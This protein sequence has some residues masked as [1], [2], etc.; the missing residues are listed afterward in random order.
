[1]P[2][3]NNDM[4]V[5][6]GVC[7][8]ECPVNAIT[9]QDDGITEIHD[10]KCIRCGR[11]HDVC[12]QEAV[13]HDSEKIPQEVVANLQW[14]R[15]LLDNFETSSQRVAFMGRMERYFNK[16]KKVIEKTL[17]VL[18]TTGNNT[19]KKLDEGIFTVMDTQN[20]QAS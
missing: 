3:I 7:I 19:I 1:M 16:E 15:Q 18:K 10:A 2:W 17:A 11:C 8:E 14:V 6:C 4:C 5:G 9:Q 13:R 12:P 20:K